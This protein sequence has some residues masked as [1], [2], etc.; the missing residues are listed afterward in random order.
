MMTKTIIQHTCDNCG[1]E[2]VDY[3]C[4]KRKYCCYLCFVEASRGKPK[5]P[6]WRAAIKAA[7]NTPEALA[8][9]SAVRLGKKHPHRGVARTQETR[10][11]IRA[12][13]QGRK[14]SPEAHAN[15]RTAQQKRRETQKVLPETCAK[16][17]A[18]KL[19]R[20][21][22]NIRGPKHPRWQGGISRE[23]Y[24]WDF[25]DE[26]KEEVRR[27]DGYKCQMC[28]AP[29][30][31]CRTALPVHHID[32]NKTNNSPVNLIAL[33]TS[34]HPETSVN[35]DHWML[36]FQTMAIERDIAAACVRTEENNG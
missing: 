3:P 26:L 15:M 28:G 1:K 22:P 17:R 20:P 25:N 10:D 16:I 29:Q 32:Y 18:A 7:A 4:K 30:V 21:R 24:G 19:G 13:K 34:C 8:A 11:K 27:R 6:E 9:K 31:E 36:F 2:F 35:R 33:C 23:P 5:S 12:A 14:L